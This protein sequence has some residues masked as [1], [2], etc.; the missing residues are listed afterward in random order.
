MR[1]TIVFTAL[2]SLLVSGCESKDQAVHGKIQLSLELQKQL[3]PTAALYLIARRPGEITGPPLA[4][5]KFGQPLLFPV[6]FSLS[7]KDMMMP[8]QTFEGNLVI[9][10]RVSQSGAAIPVNAGDVEGFMSAPY[11]PVGAK[12]VE[13]QLDQVRK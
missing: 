9:M 4:V 1:F 8:G 12:D 7:A 2:L 11:V 6:D 10:A 3:K 13:I 5:V